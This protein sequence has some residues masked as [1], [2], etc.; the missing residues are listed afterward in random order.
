LHGIDPFKNSKK[1]QSTKFHRSIVSI[2]AYSVE[3]FN[4]TL[5]GPESEKLPLGI[6][7]RDLRPEK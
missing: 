6:A 2:N 4:S 1:Q 3:K 7:N 5:S